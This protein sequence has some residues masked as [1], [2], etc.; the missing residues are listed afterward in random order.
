M[1][2]SFLFDNFLVFAKTGIKITM[3][4][5]LQMQHVPTSSL[6]SDGMVRKL[7]RF[8]ISKKSLSLSK[9]DIASSLDISCLKRQNILDGFSTF[10]L[11]LNTNK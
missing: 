10:Q 5:W 4:V 7:T 3:R 9:H 1:A 2:I 8:N 11:N 6:E